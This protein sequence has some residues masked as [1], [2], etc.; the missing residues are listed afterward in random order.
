MRITKKYAGAS[1]LGNKISRLSDRPKFS[2]QDIEVAQMDIA[3]LER[4]FQLR[5]SHGVGAPL[6]PDEDQASVASGQS[7]LPSAVQ[8]IPV[9]QQSTADT[10]NGALA[11]RFAQVGGASNIL[12][13][14][15][16]M[17]SSMNAPTP[18]ASPSAPSNLTAL[19]QANP[20]VAA[21]LQ[22]N[23]QFAAAL[24]SHPQILQ[25]ALAQANAQVIT[26]PPVAAAQA[27][28]PVAA[29]GSNPNLAALTSNA[30]FAAALAGMNAQNN[31]PPVAAQPAPQLMSSPA[32]TLVQ[33]LIKPQ[34]HA[35]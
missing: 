31:P 24:S 14:H 9:A 1:C 8:A 22:S 28:R 34:Q 2:P 29:P 23:P 5:L 33:Q 27:S 21:A 10:S 18:A 32:A 19:L 15:G 26:N 6:P 12:P 7:S 16:T 13:G 4:R 17:P 35:K 25:A 20:W 30:Q 3:R 11:S